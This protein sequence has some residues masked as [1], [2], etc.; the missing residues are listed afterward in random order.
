MFPCPTKLDKKLPKNHHLIFVSDLCD[1]GRYSKDVI[2]FV[3]RNNYRCIKGNHET[4][5]GVFLEDV[6]FHDKKDINWLKKGW[7]GQAT[8]DCYKNEDISL[9]TKHLPWINTL[10]SY[11]FLMI[12]ILYHMGMPYL[13]L[14]ED[15]S[16]MNI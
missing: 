13:I 8:V 4:Y 1:R 7:G 6:L 15:T 11:I 5:M 9:I 16:K 2:E 14:K 3:I 12:L 10:S